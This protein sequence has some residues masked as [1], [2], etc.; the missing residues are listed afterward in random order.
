M[1]NGAEDSIKRVVGK[2]REP[3]IAFDASAELL[4]KGMRFNDEMNKTFKR[5]SAGIPK[6]LYRFRSLKEANEHQEA[7]VAS[8]MARL[9][10]E[11]E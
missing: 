2:K 4:L 1:E 8:H 11:R 5:Q 10:E 7:C 3:S 9:S 6:G